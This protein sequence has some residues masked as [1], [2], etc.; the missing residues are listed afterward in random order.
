M[1]GEI[2]KFEHVTVGYDA[3]DVVRDFSCSIRQGEFVSLIGPNGSGK[4]TLIHTVTGITKLK[5]GRIF[6][7]GK[8]NETLSAKER[9]QIAAVVPQHFTADFAF[10]AREIVAMGRHPF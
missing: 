6:L 4:S 5:A 8:D 10:K 9:A 1:S 7:D 2:L 3:R